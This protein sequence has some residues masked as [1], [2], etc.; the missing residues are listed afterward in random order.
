MHVITSLVAG[1]AEAMVSKVAMERARRGR[2]DTVLCLGGPGIWGPRLQAAG[3]PVVCLDLGARRP[4]ATLSAFRGATRPAAI[5][6][7]MYHG[8]LA[9][10]ALGRAWGVPFAWNIRATWDPG[11]FGKGATRAV[12]ELNRILSASPRRI[13]SNSHE[14]VRDHKAAGFAGD[15]DVIPNGFEL[16][17]FRPDPAARAAFRGS[18]GLG[19]TDL[20]LGMA[21]RLHPMKDHAG[22]LRAWE[23]VGGSHP[24]AHLLLA[25]TGLT[26]GAPLFEGAPWR[27]RIHLLG[28]QGDMPAFQASLDV[29]VLSSAYGEA[30]PN[31][32][33]EALACG[34]PCVATDVGDSREI[35]GQAGRIVRPRDPGALAAALQEVLGLGREARRAL[36]EA[37][38]RRMEDRYSIQAIGDRY[39]AFFSELA[40]SP[41]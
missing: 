14:A 34:V 29:A 4:L 1:G 25:G 3:V 40:D 27:D 11:G 24:R 39:G 37:G 10:Y 15:W 35:V 36:G 17:R 8:N 30:F 41:R 21:A 12:M 5:L 26:P 31:A 33:G 2:M 16:E 18:L 7:W 32:L 20:A 6:G 28:E 38:R 23:Q 9:A 19:E 22:L 13:L